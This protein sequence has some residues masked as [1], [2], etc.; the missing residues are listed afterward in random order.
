MRAALVA[1]K[2]S[3]SP[4]YPSGFARRWPAIH[5]RVTI[6]ASALADARAV[7]LASRRN[8]VQRRTREMC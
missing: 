6:R 8:H 4:D 2:Q 7:R 3:G 5:R 1:S